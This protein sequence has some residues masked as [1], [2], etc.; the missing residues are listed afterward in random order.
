MY[1][2]HYEHHR[3]VERVIY[4]YFRKQYLKRVTSFEAHGPFIRRYKDSLR[5]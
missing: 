4:L 3:L 2:K 5:L 1:F